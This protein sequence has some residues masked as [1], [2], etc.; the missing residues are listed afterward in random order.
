MVAVMEE[1][2][3]DCI[4]HTDRDLSAQSEQDANKGHEPHDFG[5]ADRSTG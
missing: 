3:R 1:G 4:L 5:F 2:S